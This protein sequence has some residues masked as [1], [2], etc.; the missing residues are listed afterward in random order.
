VARR[1]PARAHLVAVDQTPLMRNVTTTTLI[2]LGLFAVSATCARAA[3]FDKKEALH[4]ISF[5]VTSP[6]HASGNTVRLVPAGLQIDN[7]PIEM[8]VAGVV[9]GA[10]VADIN[11]DRS[12]E[13][14]IYVQEPGADK[15]TTLVAFSAN[16]KR[17]L[18][19][20]YLPTLEDA[21]GAEKGY[22]GNDVMAA[23]EGTF[24]RR[25]PICGK[26]QQPT[27]KTRQLQYKLRPGEAGWQLRL[28]RKMEF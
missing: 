8:E 5:H 16:K 17:S 18:S 12:P 7:S 22:C 11:A 19:A 20:I 24:I 3:P 21:K 10:E 6:N 13:I 14:Y 9:T 2:A 26:D 15:R 25:F 1:I 4:G 28:D 27:G 23:V